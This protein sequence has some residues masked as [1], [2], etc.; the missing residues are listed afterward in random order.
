LRLELE[1]K[2]ISKSYFIERVNEEHKAINKATLDFI[3]K[4]KY[5]L[6]KKLVIFAE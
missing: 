2:K 6:W 4:E 3:L 1:N 5:N